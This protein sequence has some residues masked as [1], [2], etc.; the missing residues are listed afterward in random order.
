MYT[1]PG[2]TTIRSALRMACR[3]G[4]KA[5]GL[6]GSSQTRRTRPAISGIL[7]SPSTRISLT[8]CGRRISASSRTEFSVDGR[9]RPLTD[10]AL[11]DSATASSKLPVRSV[12]AV[13]KRLPKEC[14]CN[15]GAPLNRY[16]KSWV[17]SAS[18]LESAARQLRMSPGGRMPRLSRRRPEEPPSS[19]TVT[20]A[21]ILRV[22]SLRP[23]SSEA[24]PW[25]PPMATTRGPRSRRR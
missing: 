8:V 24:M 16:W 21:V 14:P 19:A 9:T 13:M 10:K 1:L 12:R 3:A 4:G 5:G 23:R 2:P 11:P 6:L 7:L 18:S 15:S 22:C 25:P 20:I 17:S